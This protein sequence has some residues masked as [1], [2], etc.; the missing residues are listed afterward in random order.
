M[1]YTKPFLRCIQHAANACVPG[2]GATAND[3][4]LTAGNI[5]AEC[6]NGTGALVGKTWGCRTGTDAV[7]VKSSCYDGTVANAP[8]VFDACKN[9]MT[10]S[11]TACLTGTGPTNL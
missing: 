6:M 5:G 8:N 9:G 11:D 2:S 7:G 1:K 4:F 10:P 3:T